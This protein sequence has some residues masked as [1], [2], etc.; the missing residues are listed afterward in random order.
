VLLVGVDGKCLR[1]GN[2]HV[3]ETVHGIVPGSTAADDHDSRLSDEV[4]IHT[5]WT[6]LFLL[7]FCVFERFIDDTLHF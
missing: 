1:T 6:F 3:V 7:N 2:T 5:L 4:I